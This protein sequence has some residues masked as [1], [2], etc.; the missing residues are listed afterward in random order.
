MTPNQKKIQRN[1]WIGF[2]LAIGIIF[3]LF[4]IVGMDW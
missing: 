1:R 3:G 4:V 2:I